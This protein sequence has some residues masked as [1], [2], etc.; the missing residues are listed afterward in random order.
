MGQEQL[1]E[2]QAQDAWDQ[3][4]QA[5]EDSDSLPVETPA[6]EGNQEQLQPQETEQKQ[7]EANVEAK[8]EETTAQ[9]EAEP[10]LRKE[11]AEARQKLAEVDQLKELVNQ[12]KRHVGSAEGRVAAMQREMDVAKNAAKAVDQAPSAAQIADAKVSPEKWEA[13]KAD[14]PDWAEATEA[15]L[16]ARLAGLTP[17]Q[18]QGLTTEQVNDLVANRVQE[19]EQRAQRLIEEAKIDGKYENWRDDVKSTEFM[20]WFNAQ[21]DSIKTLAS[22]TKG[23]DVIHVLDLWNKAKAAPVEQVKES[24]AAKLA[25]AATTKPGGAPVSKSVDQMSPEELWNYEAKLA[26]KRA[27]QRGL[28]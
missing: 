13:L 19:V 17:Q 27:K 5:R 23:R 28:M 10:D 20:N 14:F 3:M 8:P 18:T 1:T 24:R 25:A 22:S 9:A 26:E 16:D 7:A 11:L 15:L 21:D 6:A 2:Q 4:A 12:L